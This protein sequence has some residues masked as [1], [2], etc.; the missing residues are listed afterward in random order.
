MLVALLLLAP[1]EPRRRDSLIDAIWGESPPR[2]SEHALDNLVSR[3]RKEL[4]PD[5]LVSGP[6]GYKLAVDPESVDAVR[7]EALADDGR[8]ALAAGDPARAAALLH[9]ALGLCRG[10][11]LADLADESALADAVRRLA[12][13]R[14][15]ALEDRVDADLA[16]GAHQELVPELRTLVAEEPL[17]ERRRGQLMLALYRSGRHAEALRVY[18]DGHAYLAAE[19]GLEP[20]RALRDLELAMARHDPALDLDPTL[21]SSARAAPAGARRHFRPRRVLL[22]V[23]GLGALAASVLLLAADREEGVAADLDG[24]GVLFV[25]DAG[26]RAVP[27]DAAVGALATLGPNVWG[28]SFS[29]GQAIRVSPDRQTVTQVARVGEGPA[30]VAAARGDL[31]IADAPRNRVVRI[32]GESGQVVQKV[33]VGQ[34]PIAVTAG[35]GSVWVASTGPQTVSRI[36]PR[37][38]RVIETIDIGATPA[39]LSAGAGGV[40]VAEPDA[41]R[42]ARINA[43]SGAVDISV[44]VGAGPRS[45][46]VAN[47]AVWVANALDATVSRIDVGHGAVLATTPVGGVPTALSADG[48]GVW[49][50]VRDKHA[51]LRLTGRTARV[52]RRVRVTGRP[53]ALAQIDGRVAVAVSPTTGEHRGGT[54]RVRTAMPV[55]SLDPGACCATP[56]AITSLLYDGL[57]GI[58]RST[59]A[60]PGLVADLAV[61]L[62]APTGDGRVYTFTLRPGLR[63]STGAPVR[64][65]D[66]RRGFER[67]LRA[68]NEGVLS[69]GVLAASAGCRVPTRCDLTETVVADDAARTVS[70]HLSAPYPELLHKLT[71]HVGAPVPRTAPSSVGVKA[72]PGTGPYRVARFEP[73][74]AILL[75]RS[76]YFHEWSPTAQP[77]ARPD[78][79]VITLG[80]KP[81]NAAQEVM[82][83]AADI[84]L[85]PP[86]PETLATLR[87]EH[88]G[89]L[90]VHRLLNTDWTWLNTQAP[91]FDDIRVRRAVN[92]AVDRRA[93]IRAFGGPGYAF[94]TCQV[95]PPGI[96]GYVPNCPYT[97]RPAPD[98]AWRAPN[99]QRAR[100]LVAAA[101]TRGMPVTLWT[102]PDEPYGPTLSRVV[103]RALR[104][105]GY[106]A[107]MRVV[108]DIL[109]LRRRRDSLQALAASV[110]ADHA[111][112]AQFLAPLLRCRG[113][114]P[115][116][117]GDTPNPSA[118]CD[119]Q[120]L[121]LIA[122]ALEHEPADPATA[123]RLWA[124][125]DRRLVDQAALVPL[126][127]E[128][129]V[130]VTGPRV[131]NYSWSPAVGP[132]L[133]EIWVR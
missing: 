35:Y 91:P 58:D 20:G 54:L 37:S 40:W 116:R 132:L 41:R 70:I 1:N 19:L 79:V 113:F 27:T 82:R 97:R 76:P 75:E 16:L 104:Q 105:L 49:V 51:L 65:S 13:A 129:S 43:Q 48:D 33:L 17:R 108:K 71:G 95:L 34:S 53:D 7:F 110:L 83:R 44:S 66:F 12:D 55:D 59:S 10:E 56:S 8:A 61:G 84:S 6:G 22:A 120:M 68:G 47:R 131:G 15:L 9:E 112:A 23:L 72:L 45:V 4:G 14:A 21:R 128:A 46:S 123:R 18:R 99:L 86:S 127:N 39:A 32:D 107:R 25:G 2:D 77:A 126:V 42:V 3:V 73:G 85:D 115:Q 62:P 121:S 92:L 103:V 124:A 102:F 11:P 38:G 114:R 24:N 67:V 30:G 89:R 57:P 31:W 50:A 52:A 118:F 125:A 119:R 64:A 109:A 87:T 69:L 98:G 74:R 28:S 5:V 117:P 78:R 101:G 111:A 29:T 122:S 106:R 130:V 63:Y 80:G 133:G 81:A 60:M 90:H 36:Q 26:V 88:P 96:S 100:R 94:A 93:A